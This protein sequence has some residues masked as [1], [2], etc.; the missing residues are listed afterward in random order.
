[1]RFSRIAQAAVAATIALSSLGA[2]AG[3]QVG[4]TRVI[5][6]AKSDKRETT[7]AVRNKGDTPYVVQ[8]FI[9]DGAGDTKNMPF[10]VTPPLVRLEGGKE[11]LL[12]IRR[13]EGKTQL[14]SDRESVFWV[15]VKEIPPTDR[16]LQKDAS[17]L[18]IAVLTRV[19]LF[20]RPAGLTGNAADAPAQLKWSA[21]PGQNGRGAA[22]KVSNPT[23]YHVTFSTIEVD[24]AQK[25][26]INADMVEPQSDLL[27]PIPERAVSKVGP[28]KFSYTT[29]NDYGAVTPATQV[30]ASPSAARAASQ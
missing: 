19:K 21:V 29:I 17:A 14:P 23:P 12:M 22:L 30:T 13:V 18:K 7:L 24:G 26:S 3:I 27:I 2:Q 6:D 28:V 4:G 11:Q 16:S 20:Y 25:E 8:A 15:D 10:T 1:M 5:F 9:D